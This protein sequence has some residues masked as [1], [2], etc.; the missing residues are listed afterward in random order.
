[1][2]VI[3]PIPVREMAC[4]EF[5]SVVGKGER[6]SFGAG[7]GR[8]EDY[9]DDATLAGSQGGAAVARGGEIGVAGS[10]AGNVEGRYAA[11]R[12]GDFLWGRGHI[13]LV[14]SEG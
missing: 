6:S 14:I 1:M 12:Q 7:L 2:E 3:D 10:D 5:A 8:G 9:G 13:E 11:I 4:G